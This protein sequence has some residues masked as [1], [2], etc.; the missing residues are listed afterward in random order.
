MFTHLGE[1]HHLGCYI[2]IPFC[3]KKCDYCD[4]F[5]V[6][7]SSS[8][9]LDAYTDTI[10][11]ELEFALDKRAG[12]F[13]TIFIGGGNPA[14]LGAARLGRIINSARGHNCREI[15][16]EMNP[17]QVN[18][19][20]LEELIPSVTRLSLGIQSL[21]DEHV[22]M[23]GR[24]SDSKHV[25]ESLKVLADYRHEAQISLD[26]I[27]A[28]PGQ[29]LYDTRDDIL[30]AFEILPFDHLSVYDLI[31]EEGTPLAGRIGMQADRNGNLDIDQ[32][33]LSGD[34]HDL[35]FKRYEISN[36]A[37][38][39][40]ICVHNQHYWEMDPYLGIGPAAVSLL[41]GRHDAHHLYGVKD[42]ER[43]IY[44]KQ[45]YSDRIYEVEKLSR[46]EFLEEQ[47]IM[48]IRT[49]AGISISRLEAM[50]STE[51]RSLMHA[52]IENWITEGFV[53]VTGD[54]LSLTQTGMKFAN[55]VLVDLI[56]AL[57]GRTGEA[58]LALDTYF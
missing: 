50:F 4:F 13:E 44:E 32:Y 48:R 36:W 33:D 52:G 55:S 47:L 16:V 19:G 23:L 57:E 24:K 1:Y 35:G 28:I 25:I 15:T 20:F 45:P 9:L 43:Y 39:G 41:Y 56:L 3:I 27:D 5:S 8:S 26:F 21:H 46:T 49:S 38:N 34:L 58:P 53:S 11:R 2:H 51:L 54:R 29:G 6:E 31:I 30:R 40:K 14:V 42:I 10:I 17:E 12:G 37:R 22:R 7:H 18:P